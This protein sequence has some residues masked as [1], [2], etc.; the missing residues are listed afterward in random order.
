MRAQRSFERERESEIKTPCNFCANSMQHPP[1]ITSLLN[2]GSGTNVIEVSLGMCKYGY[3]DNQGQGLFCSG[4]HGC[5]FDVIESELWGRRGGWEGGGGGRETSVSARGRGGR[6]QRAWVQGEALWRASALGIVSSSA[7]LYLPCPALPCIVWRRIASRR[8]QSQSKECARSLSRWASRLAHIRSVPFSP[9]HLSRS[10]S[11][12]R[13]AIFALRSGGS[14]GQTL[15]QHASDWLVSTENNPIVYTHL[16]HG[17]MYDARREAFN[18]SL[19]RQSEVYD[20][21]ANRQSGIGPLELSL[22]P[23]IGVA[24]ELD[25]VKVTRVVGSDGGAAF[26]FDLGQ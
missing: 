12:C 13:A 5:V 2:P 23:S 25:P 26:V 11:A 22:I 4:A 10:R 15:L 20:F 19:W 21:E 16:F 9:A 1:D 17:E 18:A 8:I 24:G 14:V 7:L 3:M 6:S